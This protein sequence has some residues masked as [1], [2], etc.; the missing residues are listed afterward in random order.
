MDA[1]LIAQ[2]L[3]SFGESDWPR[4]IGYILMAALVWREVKGLKKEVK[5]LGES[6][7][8]SFKAGNKRFEVIEGTMRDFEHRLTI[9][10][11]RPVAILTTGV[12]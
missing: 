9:I 6:I 10:E 1:I 11:G 2:I 4:F 5:A 12:P 3:E 7:D 8:G